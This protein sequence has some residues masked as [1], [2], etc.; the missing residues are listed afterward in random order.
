[1]RLRKVRDAAEARSLLAEAEA[2]GVSRSTWARSR[3]VDARSLNAWRLNLERRAQPGPWAE[4]FHLVELVPTA[5]EPRPG[6]FYNVR[7]GPF[8]VELDE[9]FEDETLQRLLRVV[10]T[11]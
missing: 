3:G 10:A 4:P 5:R 9:R 11:C 6:Q 7:C 1:M 2:S 8:S